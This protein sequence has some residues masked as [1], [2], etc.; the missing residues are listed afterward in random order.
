MAKK[1]TEKEIKII[2]TDDIADIMQGVLE[3][4]ERVDP[5]QAHFWLVGLNDVNEMIFFEL[6]SLGS[7]NEHEVEPMKVFR[8]AVLKEVVKIIL[9]H[10]NISCRVEPTEEDKGVT[11]RLIHVGKI[12]GIDVIDHIIISSG[13]FFSF[14]DAGIMKELLDSTKWV[15]KHE[16]EEMIKK[17]HA[18]VLKAA[19]SVAKE[20]ILEKGK[21]EGKIEI[22]KGLLDSGETIEF[23][24]KSTG[25]SKEDIANLSE[26]KT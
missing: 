17:E 23:I 16:Q 26:K 8:V 24:M 7:A 2:N 22:A 12:L 21:K 20:E 11:D 25:L 4:E 5:G 10:N 14:E 18:R 3:H 13:S 9:V 6:V 19:I 15:P 1:L